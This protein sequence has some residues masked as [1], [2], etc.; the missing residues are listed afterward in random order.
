MRKMKVDKEIAITVAVVVVL[1]GF[2]Y[3][4]LRL[5]HQMVYRVTWNNSVDSTTG[6][7][8]T[9]VS[10]E[11]ISAKNQLLEYAFRPLAYVELAVRPDAKPLP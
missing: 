10:S 8:D 3:V 5:S 7:R 4:G 11:S 1:Y 9:S 6:I 2:A